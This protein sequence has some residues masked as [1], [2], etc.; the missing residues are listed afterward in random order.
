MGNK[1]FKLFMG[2]VIISA[3]SG[4]F[5]YSGKENVLYVGIFVFIVAIL[6][7]FSNKQSNENNWIHG[8]AQW[9]SREELLRHFGFRGNQPLEPGS[10]YLSYD[11]NTD[12][13]IAIPAEI[14][15]Q[16]GLILGGTGAGKSRGYFLANCAW[17]KNTSFVITDPKSELWELTSGHQKEAWRYAPGDENSQCFNWIPLCQ[18]ARTAQICARA[19]MSAATSKDTDPFWTNAEIAYLVAIFAH[20]AV[21]ANP[22][23]LAA[24]QFITLTDREVL[25]EELKNSRSKVARQQANIFEQTDDKV[26]GGIVPAVANTLQFMQDPLIQRFTSSD[27]KPPNFSELKKRPIGLYYC[28]KDND[29]DYLKPLNALFFTLVLEEIG[30]S[31]AKPSDIPIMMILDEFGNLGR[32]PNFEATITLARSRGISIWLGLQSLDQLKRYGEENGNIILENLG[33]QVFLRGI[34][35]K[36]AEYISKILGESTVV[37]NK[38]NIS[39][40]G[41]IFNKN[42]ST[43]YSQQENKR[44]LMTVDEVNRLPDDRAIVKVGNFRPMM[45]KK[46][47]Y[48]ERAKTAMMEKLKEAIG[49][50]KTEGGR[51]ELEPP[52]LSAK[53]MQYQR[54][55]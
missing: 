33:T 1:L 29:I 9:A 24:Y 46:I 55:G 35:G 12:H 21:S 54:R 28:L 22:T 37:V 44:P 10:F 11:E 8:T 23:P 42:Y 14:A 50:D 38:E 34:K 39:E 4:M 48:N 52:P 32:I 13:H 45:L 15:K 5:I 36:S 30:Q 43:T 49:N 25:L 16:H 51:I 53:G 18:E 26:K 6:V 20:I 2:W 40:S 27:I 19:L 17:I 41:G 47:Y 31:Q 7:I 3:I